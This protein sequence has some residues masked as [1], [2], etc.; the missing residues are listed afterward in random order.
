LIYV[1]YVHRTAVASVCLF[2]FLPVYYFVLLKY[3]RI[4]SCLSAR[5]GSHKFIHRRASWATPMIIQVPPKICFSPEI[6]ASRENIVV[7]LI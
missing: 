1:Q 5:L 2:G 7:S 4:R 3:V 6:A